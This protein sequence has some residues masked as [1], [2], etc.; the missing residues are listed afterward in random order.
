MIVTVTLNPALDLWAQVPKVEPGP[1]LRLSQPQRDP[2]GGGINVARVIARLG[3]DVRVFAALGGAIGAQLSEMVKAEGL[4]LDCFTLAAETRQSLS[5]KETSSGDEYRFVLP[6]P[7]WDERQTAPLRAAIRAAAP[8]GFVV[9][10]GSQPPGLDPSFARDLAQDLG[11]GRLIVDTSGPALHDIAKG[12]PT[13]IAVLRMDQAEARKLS[14]QGLESR[15]ETLAFARALR[16][17]GAADA[18]VL[19]R[20]AEGSV[21]SATSGDWSCHPP[22]V[23][24]LSKV[25]AGDSFTGAFVLAL[26][27]GKEWQE[28]LRVGTAA[29]AAAVTTA[30]T[31]LCH[32]PDVARLAAGCRLVRIGAT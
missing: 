28:A 1:K 8:A 19:A 2:G 4:E 10:S 6:G 16:Q 3:G 15:S 23:P 22:Q 29:A 18:V 11:P 27:Q 7:D 26:D 17:K 30:G 24:V 21:L 25:G 5:L 14:G 12:A 13:G 31:E 32:A 9:L 20:G